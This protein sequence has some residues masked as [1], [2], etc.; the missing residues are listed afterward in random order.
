M[1]SALEVSHTID[2]PYNHYKHLY[3][4][5]FKYDIMIIIVENLQNYEFQF[6]L[7]LRMQSSSCFVSEDLY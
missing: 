7:I 2:A 4:I 5:K 3:L 1:I 6:L